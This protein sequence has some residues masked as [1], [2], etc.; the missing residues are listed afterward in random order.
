MFKYKII[1]SGSSGNCIIV[2]DIIALDVGIPFKK[3]EP[4]LNDLKLIFISHKH[5]DHMNLSTL[6]KIN[7]LRP[8]IRF[9][10]GEYL[11]DYLIESGIDKNNID[12]VRH[13]RVYDYKMFKLS[14]IALIHD[15]FNY[16]LR[17]F[18]NG[19]K[20]LYAVDTATL[21]HIS[22]KGYNLYLIEANY[23]DEVLEQN[24]KDDLE[25]TGFSYNV[26]VKDTHLSI[27]QATEFIFK[28]ASENSVYEFIHGSKRNLYRQK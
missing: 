3:I 28:N 18:I 14:P 23:D 27:A 10:V 6:R 7:K 22:A 17:L 13:D 4:Y 11:C 21:D 1:A 20:M 8:T 16:G 26:R 2:N 12:I 15:V 25:K 19:E 24:L 5:S 9:C